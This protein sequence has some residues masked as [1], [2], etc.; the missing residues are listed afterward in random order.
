MNASLAIGTLAVCCCLA[1]AQSRP[2]AYATSAK[3]VADSIDAWEKNTKVA[4]DA[5]A[6]ARIAD[7]A[8]RLDWSK[9][10][11]PA[12]EREQALAWTRDVLVRAWLY[13][14][15]DRDRGGHGIAKPQ[16]DAYPLA[17]FAGTVKNEPFGFVEFLSAPP[18]A[19]IQRDHR[20]IGRTP[21]GLLVPGDV[22]D[23]DI[24]LS[25][26]MTCESTIQVRAGTT[27]RMTCPE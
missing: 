21:M 26:E 17:E 2:Q 27:E 11:V 8:E 25:K 14:L 15:L 10:Y 4:V 22:H 24:V 19:A 18:G 9:V 16:V 5:D 13:A 20:E 23:Y 1:A 12:R 3:S 6:R 7:D